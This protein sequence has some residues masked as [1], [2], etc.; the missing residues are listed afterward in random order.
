M[1]TEMIIMIIR[2]EMENYKWQEKGLFMAFYE[3]D[4]YIENDVVNVLKVARIVHIF[5]LS[6]SMHW[7]RIKMAWNGGA[8]VAVKI[9]FF[10]QLFD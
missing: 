6:S 9:C 3:Y 10:L 5:E 2:D 1:A 7:V 4:L 8:W